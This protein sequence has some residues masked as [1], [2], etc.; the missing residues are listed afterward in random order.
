MQPSERLQKV[1]KIGDTM[2]LFPEFKDWTTEELQALLT[3]VEQFAEQQY[4]AIDDAWNKVAFKPEK[5]FNP[6]AAH[7]L[8]KLRDE[9]RL[10]V[11][12]VMSEICSVAIFY[13]NERGVKTEGGE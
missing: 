9:R 8:D 10:A 7:S 4:K 1:L 6:K 2:A 11:T 12:A 3:D 13:L 5:F